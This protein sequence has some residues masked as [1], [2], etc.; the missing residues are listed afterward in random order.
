MVTFSAS[1]RQVKAQLGQL[2]SDREILRICRQLGYTWRDRVLNPALTVQLFLLQLLAKV[3]MRGLGHVAGISVSAQAICKAKQRLPL[4]LL[5]ELVE[6][7][8][9]GERACSAWR[10]LKVFLADGMSFMTPDTQPLASRYGKSSNQ[11][12]SACWGFPTPKLLALMDWQG[13][14]I[15]KVI[16]LPA[17][18]QEFTCL[19][20]L[21]KQMG[22]DAILLGDR[23]LVSF[24]H[25][26][27]LGQAAL[28][29]CFRLPCRLVV[30]GRRNGSRRRLRRL[31]R[32]DCLVTWSKGERRP[33]W[34]SLLRWESLPTELTLRQI[35]FRIV[36]PGSRVRWA[37]L[38]TTLLDSKAYPAEQLLDLYGKRW[39]VEV[40]FRDLKQTL[41]MA[42]LSSRSLQGVRKEILVYVL[43]YKLVRRV[44]HLSAHSQGVSEDRISFADA[45]LWLLWS[46]PGQTVRELKTNPRRRRRTAPRRLK[47]SCGRYPRLC[48][49]RSSSSKPPCTI[50]L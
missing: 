33:R 42:K 45:L 37:W 34:M 4:R 14:F 2:V 49:S 38:V 29:G 1:L 48:Q 15:H 3:A 13:G 25:L 27:L 10:G 18:R 11:R 32:Q 41:E 20:R 8:V 16:A 35:S 28:H 12:G 6:S 22:R 17:A 24:A 50:N 47:E 39:Q 43:L 19:G 36:R 30:C 7:S 44:M 5:M 26:A 46:E 31:G 40:Y 9:P 21:F 23:G